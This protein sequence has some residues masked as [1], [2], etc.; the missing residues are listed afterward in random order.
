MSNN[1]QQPLRLE[2]ADQPED[3]REA[4][5]ECEVRGRRT[6]FTRSGRPVALLMSWDEYLA[7]TETVSLGGRPELLERIRAGEAALEAGRAG[8]AGAER[9]VWVAETA[10]SALEDGRRAEIDAG[11]EVLA[12][13]AIAGVP[14]LDPLRGFWSYRSEALRIVYRMT[15]EGDVGVVDI[16]WVAEDG[17]ER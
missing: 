7:L 12:G 3:V 4:V 10:A 1:T 11:L 8:A 2:L 13:N 6:L 16:G 14:L 5:L 15:R 17:S 9:R